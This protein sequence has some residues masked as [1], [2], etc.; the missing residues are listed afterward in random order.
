LIFTKQWYI[1][2]IDSGAES[3]DEHTENAKSFCHVRKTYYIYESRMMTDRHG[4]PRLPAFGVQRDFPVTKGHQDIVY[5][6]LASKDSYD[7]SV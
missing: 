7:T 3:P 4:L 1:G 2:N 5:F 6:Y